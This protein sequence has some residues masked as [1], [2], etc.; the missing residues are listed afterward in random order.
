MRQLVHKRF[1]VTHFIIIMIGGSHF[2]YFFFVFSTAQQAPEEF[3]AINLISLAWFICL[4]QLYARDHGK[5]RTSISHRF[6]IFASQREIIAYFFLSIRWMRKICMLLWS[7]HKFDC[8]SHP[9]RAKGLFV[10]FFSVIWI[11]IFTLECYT[12]IVL[13]WDMPAKWTVS[14]SLVEAPIKFCCEC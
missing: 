7:N 13:R 9:I 1:N 6:F 2:G 5:S 10:F 3:V 14:V 8:D 12:T 11:F 4:V